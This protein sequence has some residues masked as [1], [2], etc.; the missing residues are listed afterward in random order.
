MFANSLH[1]MKNIFKLISFFCLFLISFNAIATEDINNKYIEYTSS[2][3]FK[4]SYTVKQ[5]DLIN[6]QEFKAPIIKR[7]TDLTKD[8]QN[9]NLIQDHL[10][11]EHVRLRH[12]QI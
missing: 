3:E 4:R 8:I 1:H 10:I 9:N 12:Q 6:S 11:K 5:L 7:I 2:S